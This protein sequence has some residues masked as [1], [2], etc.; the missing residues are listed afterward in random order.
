MDDAVINVTLACP[1]CGCTQFES[2]EPALGQEYT[3]EWKFTCTNCG[4]TLTRAQL[5]E[6]NSESIDAAVEE[7]SDEIV[8]EAM[9]R[10]DRELKKSGLK[11]TIR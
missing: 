6:A 4:R 3:D 11:V 5:I 1:V 2:E 7:N 10:I 9:K 8:N